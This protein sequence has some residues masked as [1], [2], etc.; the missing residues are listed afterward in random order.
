MAAVM[1]AALV[2]CGGSP[3]ESRTT[4]S[5]PSAATALPP[6]SSAPAADTVR[7]TSN[8][9]AYTVAHSKT[10]GATPDGSG[11]WALVVDVVSGGDDRVADALNRAVQASAS[12][13][14]ESFKRDA[15]S[16]GTWSFDTDPTLHF[17]GASIAELIT[18][19]YMRAGAAHPLL[20]TGTVVIDSRSATPITLGDLFT[21]KDA[22]LE[23]LSEQSKLLLPA[24]LSIPAPMGDEPGNAPTEANFANWIPTPAGM[25]IHFADYQFGHGR[26]MITVPWAAL[27]GL[28]APSM[29][30]LRQPG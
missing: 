5:T 18:G 6:S 9:K 4:T 15:G 12:Q 26:P 8:G 19:T 24:V 13:Q 27:D 11:K 17:G 3:G 20:S 29:E 25:E 22:G 10:E 16:D 21:D 30:A 23:Q 7:G 1:L 14:L 28:L 2:G